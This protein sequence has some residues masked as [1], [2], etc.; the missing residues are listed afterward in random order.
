M[1]NNK[2][3]RTC[4][5]KNLG[6]IAKPDQN[7][8]LYFVRD[9]QLQYSLEPDAL[10]GANGEEMAS[11]RHSVV[12]HVS[13]YRLLGHFASKYGLQGSIFFKSKSND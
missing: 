11:C 6:E 2:K 1:F 7:K 9:K 13:V 10:F 12:R 3:N 4:K 8:K 5:W